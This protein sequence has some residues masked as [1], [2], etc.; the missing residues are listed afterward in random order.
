MKMFKQA[1]SVAGTSLLLAAPAFANPWDH[2]AAPPPNTM[3][4]D[5]QVRASS[6]G[7]GDLHETPVAVH[8]DR[9]SQSAARPAGPAMGQ[10]EAPAP[11]PLKGEMVARMEARGLSTSDMEKDGKAQ[12]AD[13][14]KQTSAPARGA[15]DLMGRQQAPPPV[16]L[17]A[18]V[19]LKM[20]GEMSVDAAKS[21]PAASLAGK[22]D[23]N[24]RTKQ[25]TREELKNFT[26]HT[27][28]SFP[29]NPEGSDDSDDKSE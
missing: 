17:K 19:A 8:V 5:F 29:F 22:N 16:P 20:Q 24:G 9:P 26:K 1:L 4:P 23:K 6:D 14:A 2:S 18:Q 12:A 28:L 25:H 15:H 3:R 21:N 11:V 13:L 10:R 7:R 27:G